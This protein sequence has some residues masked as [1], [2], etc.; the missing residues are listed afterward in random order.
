MYIPEKERIVART[1]QPYT[2]LIVLR[3]SEEDNYL[4]KKF[5]VQGTATMLL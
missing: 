2:Y 1:E 3:K 5:W 4:Q